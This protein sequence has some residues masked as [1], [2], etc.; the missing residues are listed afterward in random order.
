MTRA[1]RRPQLV[2]GEILSP[3][4]AERYIASG[5]PLAGDPFARGRT[6]IY[7]D[8]R[9]DWIAAHPGAPEPTRDMV[10][11]WFLGGRRDPTG[12]TTIEAEMPTPRQIA[13]RNLARSLGY[14]DTP[15]DAIPAD[16]RQRLTAAGDAAD[17]VRTIADPAIDPMTTVRGAALVAA[18]RLETFGA[19]RAPGLVAVARAH[20]VAT[21]GAGLLSG[22][23]LAWI[24]GGK[25]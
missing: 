17:A 22:L 10:A 9:S 16:V 7:W 19:E 23:G 8:V 18:E 6:D 3:A 1:A 21:F 5:D 12:V 4:E 25:S 15:W 11:A 14:G 13:M 2:R 20:P 24:A